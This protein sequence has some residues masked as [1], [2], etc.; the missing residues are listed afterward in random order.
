MNQSYVKIFVEKVHSETG[1]G[2]TAAFALPILNRLFKDPRGIFAV[3]V[4]PAREIAIQITEQIS[5]FGSPNE[6][7]CLSVYGGVSEMKQKIELEN[8]PHIVVGTPGRLATLLQKSDIAKKYLKNAEFVV[9]DEADKMA[10]PTLKDFLFEILE[11]IPESAT[12]IYSSATIED[13]DLGF[14]NQLKSDRKEEI[15]KIS[16]IRAIEKA[17]SVTLKYI[18]VPEMVKDAYLVTLIEMYQDKEIIIFF[19]N[20]E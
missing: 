5:F 11:L 7:R 16:T 8:I 9:I 13:S 6:V 19:N 20:C 1:S 2:K 14:I 3:I 10:D 17:K 4:A 12:R 18:L 15:T